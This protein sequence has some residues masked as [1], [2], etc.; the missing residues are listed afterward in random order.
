MNNTEQVK[1]YRKQWQKTHFI[2]VRVH[3]LIWYY[4]NRK[5][6]NLMFSKAKSIVPD[7]ADKWY[8]EHYPEG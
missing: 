1:V 5:I 8:L 4:R 6:V 3:K 7:E 2:R